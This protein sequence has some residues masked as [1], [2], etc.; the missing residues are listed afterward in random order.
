MIL[1]LV[2]FIALR[3]LRWMETP[4]KYRA[5]A[6]IDEP[7]QN[8]GM[9]QQLDRTRIFTLLIELATDAVITDSHRDHREITAPAAAAAN[10]GAF[11]SVCRDSDAP[12][13]PG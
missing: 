11:P 12:S 10:G 4:L 9:I 8:P 2:A 13:K 1:R 5:L 3:A 7:G 6:T